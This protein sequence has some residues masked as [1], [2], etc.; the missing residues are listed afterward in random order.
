M[1]LFQEANLVI[2]ILIEDKETRYDT[3]IT[4]HGHFKC[5]KC[6]K[7]YDFDF[8][9]SE[10]TIPDLTGFVMEEYHTYIKG[11]CKVCQDQE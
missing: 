11:I 5:T 2:P 1:D 3:N 10:A 7:I 8:D 9:L 6:G 4:N